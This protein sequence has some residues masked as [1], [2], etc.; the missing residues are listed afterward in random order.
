MSFMST[1]LIVKCHDIS[2][3]VQQN[4]CNCYDEETKYSR[5]DILWIYAGEIRD[6]IGKYQ[7]DRLSEIAKLVLVQPH[8]NASE[9]KIFSIVKK[10]KTPFRASMGFHTLGSI[11]TV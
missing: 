11:L 8:S 10:K 5:T 7:L 9:E 2:N 3:S 4:A 1:F 6:C